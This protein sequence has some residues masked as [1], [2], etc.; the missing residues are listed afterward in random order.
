[1]VGS[2]RGGSVASEGASVAAGA[3]DAAG[4]SSIGS[5]ALAAG[6]PQPSRTIKPIRITRTN[7][8]FVAFIE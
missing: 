1:M 8:R 6:A 5:V 2:T 3:S 7:V 4:A